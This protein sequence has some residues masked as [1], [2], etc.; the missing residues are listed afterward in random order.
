L[1]QFAVELKRSK[2]LGV[3]VDLPPPVAGGAK[4]P[5]KKPIKKN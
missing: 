4:P 1:E 3:K 5:I 2:A